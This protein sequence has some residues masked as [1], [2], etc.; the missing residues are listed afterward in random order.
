MSSE[1]KPDFI[2]KIVPLHTPRVY[3]NCKN[4]EKKR[5]FYCSEK[6]RM[7]AH[8]KKLDVWLIYKCSVC[9]TTWNCT[10]L[11]RVPPSRIPPELYDK[12][13]NNDKETAW[14]YA[15]D[16]ELLKRNGAEPDPAVEYVVENGVLN[17]F[18]LPRPQVSIMITFDY[19]V[20]VRLDTLLSN[21]LSMTRKQLETLFNKRIIE[22]FPETI[23]DLRK[24]LKTEIMVLI[25]LDKIKE[26]GITPDK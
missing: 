3:R 16:Y 14:R 15:F 25:N 23:R 20:N 13:Q 1:A 11:T 5:E 12:L 17:L 10:I 19:R 21:N 6:F 22:V 24:K 7:N 26:L 18:N 9:D 8:Q 4:C 2:L